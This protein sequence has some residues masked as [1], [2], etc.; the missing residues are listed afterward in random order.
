MERDAD[1]DADARDADAEAADREADAA[2]AERDA[3]ALPAAWDADA[4]A[5][6]RDA[7][8][9]ANAAWLTAAAA[10]SRAAPLDTALG[11]TSRS[12]AA[13]ASRSAAPQ[14]PPASGGCEPGYSPCIP[15]GEGDIDCSSGKGNG[16]RYV[17]GP[18][19]VTGDDP[20]DLDTNDADNIGCENG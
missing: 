16:P 4:A 11:D 10:S 3:D 20:Y 8:S 13:E 7:W 1:A 19:T 2:A 12:A 6:E 17:H 14:A 15:L 18:V 9:D 5:A